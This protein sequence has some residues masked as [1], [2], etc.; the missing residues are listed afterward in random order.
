MHNERWHTGRVGCPLLLALLGAHHL[1]DWHVCRQLAP[2]EHPCSPTPSLSNTRSHF[3]NRHKVADAHTKPIQNILPR[4]HQRFSVTRGL[5]VPGG[6][7]WDLHACERAEIEMLGPWCGAC[8]CT[9][10]P[11]HSYTSA[12]R[13]LHTRAHT[14]PCTQ[15]TAAAPGSAVAV[16][17]AASPLV[18]MATV[19]V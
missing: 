6:S 1:C 15:N 10:T 5:L 11:K 3:H 4:S 2:A 13:H 9:P 12:P 7:L 19:I 16:L 18:S 17:F 14:Y 8:P